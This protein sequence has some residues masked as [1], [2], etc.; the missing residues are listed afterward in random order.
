M[1]RIFLYEVFNKI[2]ER[3][4]ISA[5]ARDLKLPQSTVS[6]HLKTL[7]EHLRARLI[8]RT[9][10]SLTPTEQGLRFYERSRS[11]VEEVH[12]TEASLQETARS[13]SGLLRLSAA[14]SFGESRLP[15]II[16]KM[17]EAFPQL[18][19]H[20]DLTDRLVDLAEERIDIALRF[21]ALGNPD[22][23]A[24]LIG[25]AS[26]ALYASPAYLKRLGEPKTPRQ[27]KDHWL[28]L[29]GLEAEF[30]T[31][32]LLKGNRAEQIEI[33]RQ[34]FTDSGFAVISLAQAGAGIC[35]A[36]MFL[37][38]DLVARGELKRVL[39]QYTGTSLPLHA[40]RVPSR[41]VRP[42]IKLAM[43][44]LVSELRGVVGIGSSEPSRKTISN[45]RP[46]PRGA[47][48]WSSGS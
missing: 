48:G 22:L 1:D 39:P 44:F 40:L 16:A 14:L 35:Q 46:G 28:L 43:D 31:L 45:E 27:L 26:R 38:E 36:A 9:T 29:P 6:R 11:L 13:L 20:L 10:Y 12:A 41:F 17:H 2:V 25:M 42:K 19:I 32:T 7:E 15:P 4:N 5:A 23:V 24:K 47:A 3:G 30:D 37:A 8:E 33:K 34:I 21:G 18:T